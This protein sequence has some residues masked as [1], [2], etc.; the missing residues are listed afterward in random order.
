MISLPFLK[1]RRDALAALYG[2]IV[3]ASRA[4]AAYRDFGVADTSRAA[5]SASRW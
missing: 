3:A 2:D 5:S 1:P 4:P